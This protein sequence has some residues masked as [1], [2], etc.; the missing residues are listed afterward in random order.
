MALKATPRR[1]QPVGA[2]GKITIRRAEIIP[3]PEQTQRAQAALSALA[4]ALAHDIDEAELAAGGA[5]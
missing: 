1:W 2:S 3:T 5:Q 4:R